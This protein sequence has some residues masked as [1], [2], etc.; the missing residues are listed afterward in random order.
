MM[1]MTEVADHKRA[2]HDGFVLRDMSGSSRSHNDS[3]GV[4]RPKTSDGGR[5]AATST[6]VCVLFSSCDADINLQR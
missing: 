4:K 6:K 3:S 2:S 5:G 1:M